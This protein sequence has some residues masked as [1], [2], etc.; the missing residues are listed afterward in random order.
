MMTVT[1]V[2]SSENINIYN[3]G[4]TERGRFVHD[5]NE[6]ESENFQQRVGVAN[7]G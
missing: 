4:C 7:G 1:R 6:N 3:V 2:E 5:E